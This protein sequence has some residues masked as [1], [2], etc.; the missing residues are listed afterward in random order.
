MSYRLGVDVGGTFTDLLLVNESTGATWSAKVPST[1]ADQSIGVLNGIVR[2]CERAGIEPSQIDHVMHGTTVATNTVL[3]RTGAKCGLVTTRG[4]RQ[5]LQIARSFVPGG[6]GGWIVYNKS[7]PMAPLACTVE[8][9]ERIGARG[10]IVEALDEAKLRESLRTLKNKGIEA[11]TVCL[12]NSFANDVHERR[13]RDIALEELPGIPVS[14]SSEV[15][16][17]MQE[18]ERAVTTVANSYVRPGVQRYVKNLTQKLAE[19]ASKVKLHILRSDGG[20]AAAAAAEAFPVNLLMSG[21][22]GGVTGAVWIAKQAGF[23]NVLTVDVGGTSTDVA[24]IQNGEARLRR[25]TSVGDVTVRASSV[26]IRTVGAGGGSIAHVPELTKALRVGP[27]SAG[28]DP[29]P[30]A[31]DRGGTE[32]TVT[33]ANVVLGY[34][35]EIQRLGGDL[36]LNRESSAKAVQKIADAL[37]VS[38]KDAAEG[39]YK[40]VNEN[41]TGALRLV[42]VE[43]GYDPRDYALM[44]FG[45]AGPLH[46]NALSR[47]LGSWPAII[48]PG[49][50]VLCATGDATTALRDERSRTFVRRF[51]ETSAQELAE[52]FETLASEAAQALETEN[53]S[54]AEMR[55]TFEADLRYHGQGL[56][57]TVEVEL[58]EL[59]KK[60]LSAISDKFDEEHKRL[61]TFAL[62]LEH[63]L[64]SLRAAVRGKG[65]EVK[66][67][68]LA[69]GKDD[70]SAAIIGQQA[71]YMDGKDYTA[72]VYD[73]AK[74]QA[75]NRVPGP[76]I[77][78]EMDSTTVILPGH[79]GAIDA[80]G[81]ILIYP[82]G[83]D[84]KAARERTNAQK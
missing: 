16:P 29:G 41:M 81:N 36:K 65:I 5:V 44:A 10:E 61:F 54:K 11:L 4:Y 49:P 51:S 33:D 58:D 45:G 3:T 13:V 48:P 52:I 57:L 20:L 30:A 32:P 15:V 40:I 25:E 26:D 77:V 8:A 84:A 39:I 12:I 70:A 62:D 68:A 64:V 55:T 73:R 24:L 71:V 78:T 31:Y 50:G 76:A 79:H 56:R 27:Q 63:E 23:P 83:Y 74:L 43:Q 80:F 14:I 47:L 2:V 66:R 53:V 19:K 34:M 37:N 72:S 59:K 17:E 22:A 35:P 46:A 21:P 82:D 60:G 75:G 28:A 18:Y 42:S 9:H 67:P 38:L 69:Q 6:L 1:P 7:L